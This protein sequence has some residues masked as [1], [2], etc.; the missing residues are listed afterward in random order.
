MP[1]TLQQATILPI[2]KLVRIF[3]DTLQ[4]KAQKIYE[5]GQSDHLFLYSSTGGNSA[6]NFAFDQQQSAALLV[7]Q[8]VSAE[9]NT[10]SQ[11][12]V[13][14]PGLVAVTYTIVISYGVIDFKGLVLGGTVNV[15]DIATVIKTY[16]AANSLAATPTRKRVFLWNNSGATVIVGDANVGA[17]QGIPIA[18]GQVLILETSAALTFSGGNLIATEENYS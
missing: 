12:V 11:V 16:A 4:P 15:T 2:P 3:T 18:N 7:G 17:A 13:Q 1:D 9:P 14:N 6:L 5:T 8:I 10:F